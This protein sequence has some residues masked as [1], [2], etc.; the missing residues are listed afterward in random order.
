MK[1]RSLPATLFI[2]GAALLSL[3]AVTKKPD[4]ILDTQTDSVSV[5][6]EQK[7]EAEGRKGPASPALDFFPKQGFLTELP[8]ANPKAAAAE[9]AQKDEMD[10]GLWL[11]EGE[12][13]DTGEVKPGTESDDTWE[14]AS[15][16]DEKN[17][18]GGLP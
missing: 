1:P 12:E 11:E 16:T 5:E 17:P 6:E 4:P 10:L 9:P 14:D 7:E 18:R 3:A 8:V 13:K 15:A 2:L